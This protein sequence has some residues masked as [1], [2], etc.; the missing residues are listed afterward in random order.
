MRLIATD[1]AAPASPD[2]PRPGRGPHQPLRRISARLASSPLCT[3]LRKS[4][5]SLGDGQAAHPA[6]ADEAVNCYGN[7]PGGSP[8]DPKDVPVRPSVSRGAPPAC[9]HYA[10]RERSLPDRS[11]K[12]RQSS[13]ARLRHGSGA[14]PH[15]K[16]SLKTFIEFIPA[17][18]DGRVVPFVLFSSI[19][20]WRSCRL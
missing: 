3:N 20:L 14:A 8:P 6:D 11:R 17:E 15:L 2:D 13:A 1:R 10:Q 18:E 4:A 9:L 5:Q 7:A 12:G 19:W 16:R